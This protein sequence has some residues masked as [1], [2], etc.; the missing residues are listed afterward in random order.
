MAKS[1]NEAFNE[2][3]TNTVNL[4]PTRT[5][6]ARGS[7]DWLITQLTNLPSKIDDF[8]SLYEGK[9]IKFGSFARNTK[10]RPLDDIDLIL[11]FG[12]HGSTY[13]TIIHGKNYILSVP[14]T[15]G[16]LRKL[17]NGDNTLNSIKLVNKLVSSLNKIDKYKSAEIHRRQEAATLKL[18]SYEWNFDIVPALYT[19]TGY[20]LIPDG[21]GGWKAT[22][23]R[24]DQNRVSAINQKHGGKI[25]QIIRTLKYWN[26]TASMPTIGSYLFENL[27]LNY[28]DKEDTEVSTWIDLNIINFW[29][30]LKDKIYYPVLDP[31][32]FQGDINCLIYED[33]K[34]ISAKAFDTYKKGLEAYKIETEENNQE[35]AINKWRDIFGNEFPKYE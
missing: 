14:E 6:K 12:A 8:P 31:K 33:R 23:P 34:K 11:T 5:S 10:I 24:I 27:A 21:N 9:H 35:K 18:N 15:A 13:N 22:D 20:Y 29:D 26:K 2:F 17:C 7:R 28:F 19:D 16:D 1:V 25:L 30:Y 32:G 3:N 4:D